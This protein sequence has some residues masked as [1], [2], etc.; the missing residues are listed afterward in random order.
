VRRSVRAEWTK[1][2][3]VRSSWWTMLALI[4]LAVSVTALVTAGAE[5]PTCS[6][7]SG[8]CD[9]T[10]TT[11]LA[12]SGVL[13]AQ[14]AAVLLGV[15]VMSSEYEPRMIRATFAANPRRTTVFAA[16]V[17]VVSAAV[18]AAAVPAVLSSILVGR[19]V[20]TAHGFTAAT[21]HTQ[22]SLGDHAAQRAAYG[23][24]IYLVLVGLLSLGIAA[25]LRHTASAVVSVTTLLYGTYLVTL[26]VPMSTHTLHQV[27]SYTPMTAG[28]AVQSTI[29]GSG[30]P[31]IAPVAGISVLAGYAVAGCVLG[32]LTLKRRD[33]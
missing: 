24:V 22:Q 29:T 13:F 32:C 1:L 23:T 5:V 15:S 21:G 7:T 9:A 2:R 17:A 10:D 27:Q 6:T 28:L 19:A 26:I 8:R 31:P 12:L 16:K 4:G 20:L 18:A 14:L 11:A 30:G 25:V 33:A 3:T